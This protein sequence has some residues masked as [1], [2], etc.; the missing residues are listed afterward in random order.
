VLALGDDLG[1]CLIDPTEF[2][3]AML[4]LAI[5]AKDAMPAGGT[6][7]IATGEAEPD[8]PINGSS[9]SGRQIL[10]SV[11]DTG[12]GMPA[13]VRERAF[14]PFFTTKEVGKGTGLGL[15]QV[16]GFIHQSGG[17]IAIDSDVGVGTSMRL[18]FPRTAAVGASEAPAKARAMPAA[19]DARIVLVVEDNS[20]VREFLTETLETLGHTVIEANT[21]PAALRVLESGV[22]VDAVVTD[23]L[24]PDGMSGFELASRIRRRLPQTAIVVTSGAAA[25]SAPPPEAIR[26]IPILHK[27][28]RRDELLRALRSALDQSKASA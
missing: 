4:N 22:A 24:M 5:N 19:A 14:D 15:S 7:T 27:P 8:G 28:F 1:A 25:F 12:H 3:A 10:V 9:G 18:Y 20:D 26:D 13:E 11:T 6:L 23:V 21:A 2:Q 16:Y 17:H